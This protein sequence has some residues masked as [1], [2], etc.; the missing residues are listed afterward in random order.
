[1]DGIT[2]SVVRDNLLYD[3][4]ASGISLY[5]IDGAT[6]S[7]NNLVVN[8]TIVN[9]TGGRWCVNIS[10]SPGNT[11]LNNI[12]YN[13]H[14]FRGVITTDPASRA[15]FVSDHNSLMSRFSTDTG[16]TVI[17]FASW[18]A[19][20][21]DTHSF[22]ATPADLFITPGSDF[23]LSATSPALDTGT[24]SNAPAFDVDGNP[25]PVG[26]GFDIGAYE[27]QLPNCGD[28][29]IDA[30]E[31]CGEPGLSCTDACTA[32]NSCICAQQQPVCGDGKICGAEQCEV[33]ADC[34]G[35]VCHSCACENTSACDSGIVTLRP[36]LRLRATPFSLVMS[37]RAI[38]PKPWQGVNPLLNG[39]RI[40]VD[41]ISGPGGFDITI[42]GGAVANGIGWKVDRTGKLWTYSDRSGS[43]GGVTRVSVRDR[44]RT[45]DGLVGWSVRG[46]TGSVL[47][48]DV[49]QVRAAVVVGDPLECAEIVWNPPGASR[50]RCTGN[51][52][53]LGCR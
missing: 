29:S 36:A 6:G 21:Y 13:Y 34:G 42:P 32:C 30:A 28:G 44:S 39:M 47:L 18:Q 7:T 50:P 45:T 41:A 24:A 38:I 12:L 11:V 35:G 51:T 43:Q 53:H 5:Q 2:D 25:R 48:P 14:A 46:R 9:A 4:H 37:G 22:L 52:A 33:D 15:G 49:N 31:Q 26:G 16:D 3:N 19:L 23:H 10:D 20:G 17:S 8:N 27:S 40:R 1:M